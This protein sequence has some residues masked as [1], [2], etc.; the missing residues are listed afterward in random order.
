MQVR[1]SQSGS[2]LLRGLP[3]LEE[4]SVEGVPLIVYPQDISLD[5]TYT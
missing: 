3:F 4:A 1:N 5:H 2:I